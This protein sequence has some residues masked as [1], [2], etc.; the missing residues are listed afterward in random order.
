MPYP[1]PTDFN[2]GLIYAAHPSA[3]KKISLPSWE[4]R[5][6]RGEIKEQ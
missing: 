1:N 3:P 6:K 4:L 2:I 5:P